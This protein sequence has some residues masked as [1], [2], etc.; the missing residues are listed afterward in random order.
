MT[1]SAGGINCGTTCSATFTASDSVTLTASP[2]AGYSFS[3]WSGACAGVTA[4]TCTI[5]MST[6][7]TAA[8]TF[9]VTPVSVAGAPQVLYTDILSG[10]NTGGENG[11]GIYLSIFG[12]NFGTT[13]LGSAVKVYINNVE[14][15]NYRYQGLSKGRTDIQQLTVQIGALGNPT[16]GTALPIKVVVNGVASNTD[17]T[18]MVNPGRILFVDNVAGN[19]STA[20]AG[21]I[22]KPYRYVQT[23]ALY[24][25]GAWPTA[26]AGDFIVMRGHGTSAPWTD[27]GFEKYFMRFRDKSGSAPTGAS[28]T[29]PIVVMG[30]PNEDVYI[31][32]LLANG[33]TAG[34]MSGVNGQSWTGMGQWVGLTNLRIDCEGYDGPISQQIWGHNWRVVNNDLSASTAPRT[35]SSIPRMAGITGNGNN[36]VWLGNHIHDIQGSSGE[37]HGIYIDGDGSYEIA[38]NNVH[39][40]RDGNGINLYANGGNGSDVINNV[41]L[42]HNV[43]HDVSKHGINIADGS[44]AG[45]KVWNNVVYNVAYAAVRFNTTDLTGAKIFNNT[46]YNTYT[47]YDPKNPSSYG[48]IT[49]DWNLPSGALD[50]ENNIFSVASGSPYNSGSNGVPSSAGTIAHNLWFNGSD[51]TGFDSAP[52]AG[53][54]KF[55]T[56]GSDFHLQSG[57]PAIGVGVATSAV[58]S[59]VTTD[60]DAKSRSSTMDLG[61]LKY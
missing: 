42:H 18:F 10:P 28:G 55:V 45:F 52:V 25:G 30:Y 43:F 22:T 16:A 48:A 40:I 7:Q 50:I 23:P 39:N 38:Y 6:N 59:L 15:D 9:T 41:N 31:R 46:F 19:D 47:S 14:V 1:A 37:C 13:G 29:G 5:S 34:C 56:A 33:M 57:S 21:D 26:R 2:S 44:K 12:K 35:G 53:N 54:P 36:S 32:G 60:Y 58:T 3:S 49:N 61:A 8:A 17:K 27:V 51:T 20:A 24:T 4:A 11:K